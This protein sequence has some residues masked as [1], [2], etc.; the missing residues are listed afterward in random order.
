[1]NTQCY[2]NAMENGLV[3]IDDDVTTYK[4]TVKLVFLFL[5]DV[6]LYTPSSVQLMLLI[7]LVQNDINS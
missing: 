7:Q 5:Y 6:I 2:A 3:D 4:W 1:M